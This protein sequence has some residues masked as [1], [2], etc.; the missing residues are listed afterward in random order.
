MS[1]KIKLE[2]PGSWNFFEQKCHHTTLTVKRVHGCI[3]KINGQLISESEQ[4]LYRSKPTDFYFQSELGT[5][6][7]VRTLSCGGLTQRAY[8]L[9]RWRSHPALTSLPHPG[10]SSGRR[11]EHRVYWPAALHDDRSACYIYIV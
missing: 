11:E 3:I 1:D 7:G 8:C 9:L 6:S 4:K 10:E 5:A 2:K